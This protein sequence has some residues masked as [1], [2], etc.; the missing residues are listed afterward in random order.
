MSIYIGNLSY[1]VTDDDLKSVFAEYGS[2]T[3]LITIIQ[4]LSVF[5]VSLWFIKKKAEL[6]RN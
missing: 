5:F 3:K 4:F 6:S 2:V 1:E